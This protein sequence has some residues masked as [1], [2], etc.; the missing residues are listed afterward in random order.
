MKKLVASAAVVIAL[1]TGA[2]HA[3]GIVEPVTPPAVIIEDT[4]SNSGHLLVPAL[5][6][7]FV[8]AATH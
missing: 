5:F 4:S 2:S 7:I 1:A 6:V 3:G 8:L